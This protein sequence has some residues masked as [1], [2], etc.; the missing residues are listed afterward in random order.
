MGLV[1]TDTG[2]RG[3]R[4]LD[5]GEQFTFSAESI[6]QE[7]TGVHAR[8]SILLDDQVLSYDL[9][10]VE[11]DRERVHLAKSAWGRLGEVVKK[12]YPLSEIRLDLDDFCGRLWSAWLSR[13]RAE[14]M[15]G[16]PDIGP[17]SFLLEP[18][19]PEGAGAI[20][21]SPPGA[22]KSYVGLLQA[23]SIDAGCSTI[24]PV[25]QVPTLF[26]NLERG[27]LSLKRRIGL[28]NLALG[29][30]QQ[31]PLLFLN[32]RGR[33]LV[34]VMEAVREDIREYKVE[35]IVLDSLSRAGLGS[36]TEDTAAN[37]A[38]DA[39]NALCPTWL[40]LAHT[41]RADPTHI[42]GSQMFD[43]AID[44]GVQ[45][46]SQ[47]LNDGTL[48]I[49]LQVTKSNDTAIPPLEKLALEFDQYG[50]SAVRQAKTHE[51]PEL[52]AGRKVSM[53][54]EVEQHLLD[55]GQ[56]TATEIALE[57]GHQRAKISSVLQ[58]SQFIRFDR[59]PKGIPYGVKA[60]VP[61][62]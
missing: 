58:G 34:S 3:L 30:E 52:T 33:S 40:A 23:V 55:V 19:V 57:T 27:T 51:F 5:T 39:L 6:R 28:V 12:A 29:L 54:E 49:G 35:M 62:P 31:R 59:T 16:D 9:F 15:G 1:V 17:P 38:M 44:V 53:T 43:A 24:W 25:K 18:Y 61:K 36:L 47:R 26:I 21:Y 10:N 13:Y 42:F 50:L 48:G 37:A 7:R 2:V 14:M 56:A 32:A 60:S 45:L 8:V 4:N 46:L 22:G 20:V 41:P 11:R